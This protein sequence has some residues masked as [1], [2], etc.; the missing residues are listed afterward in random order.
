MRFRKHRDKFR[1]NTTGGFGFVQA[2]HLKTQQASIFNFGKYGIG[3]IDNEKFDVH[4][5]MNHL[6]TKSRDGPWNKWFHKDIRISPGYNYEI[7]IIAP[8]TLKAA[9]C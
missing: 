3:P 5:L 4:F 2:A 9:G 7:R 6:H 8:C 1:L